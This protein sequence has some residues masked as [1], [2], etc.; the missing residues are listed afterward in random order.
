MF[1]NLDVLKRHPC[2]INPIL[3][4]DNLWIIGAKVTSF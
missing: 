1:Y 3:I 4:S 2:F